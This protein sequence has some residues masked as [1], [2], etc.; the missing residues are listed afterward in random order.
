MSLIAEFELTNPILLDTRRA[1]PDVAVQVEDEQLSL[2]DLPKLV[3]WASGDADDLE[4]FERLLPSDPT[5]EAYERL[6]DL[7]GRRLYR[8][9]LTEAGRVGMTYA[10]AVELDITFLKIWGSGETLRYR[11][12]IP[13]R[14]ALFAYRDVCRERNLSFRLVS[15]FQGEFSEADEFGV[16]ARQREVL[17]HAL[18]E[19]YFDVPRQTTLEELAD[20][21]DVSDQALSAILRRGQANLL[22]HTLT[23][24]TA[25]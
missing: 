9:S 2:D 15:L 25:T 20:D 13:S 17:L 19:G 1:V 14:E 11:A 3:F 10:N 12:Q 5:I 16:T 8:I 4:Q 22:R 18:E 6:A 21:L 7:G 24:D 23:T